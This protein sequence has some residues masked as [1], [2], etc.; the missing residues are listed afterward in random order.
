MTITYRERPYVRRRIERLLVQSPRL[1]L[2]DIAQNHYVDELGHRHNLWL[3]SGMRTQA[4]KMSQELQERETSAGLREARQA[5]DVALEA[6]NK[7]PVKREEQHDAPVLVYGDLY[8][9]VTSIRVPGGWLYH[10]L[11][12]NGNGIATCFVPD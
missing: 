12:A 10:T 4:R 2:G 9:T 7:P 11:L 6:C 3:T 8:I 5:F 1:S